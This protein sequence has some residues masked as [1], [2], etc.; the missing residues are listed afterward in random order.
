MNF[1]TVRKAAEEQGWRIEDTTDGYMFYPPDPQ[2]GPV[3][4]HRNPG[5]HAVKKNLSLMKRRGLIWPPP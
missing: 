2:Q 3:L 5:E 1:R 4:F